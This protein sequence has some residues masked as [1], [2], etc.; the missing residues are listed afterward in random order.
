METTDL[1]PEPGIRRRHSAILMFITSLSAAV[2]VA[3]GFAIVL[4]SFVV[5]G[6]Y[7]FSLPTTFVWVLIGIIGAASLWLFLWVFSRSWH[8]ERRLAAGDEIDDPK[9][10]ILQNWR[11]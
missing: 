2:C 5:A 11:D 9:L 6:G 1:P 10:S 3:G 8:V 7:W 4:V